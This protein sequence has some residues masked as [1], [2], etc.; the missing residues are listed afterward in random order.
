MP[1]ASDFTDFVS[2]A[3]SNDVEVLGL[4]RDRFPH[5]RF[6]LPLAGAAGVKN[7]PETALELGSRLPAHFLRLDNGRTAIPMF[8]R[9]GFCRA[10]ADR[11][12]W[13]TDGKAIKTLAV[14][15]ATALEYLQELLSDSDVERVIVNPLSAADLHLARTDIEAIAEGRHWD[16][17]WFYSKSGRLKVPVEIEGSASILSSIFRR[18]D[19]VL[20]KLTEREGNPEVIEVDVVERAPELAVGGPLGELAAEL[21]AL[22]SAERIDSIELV[23]EKSGKDVRVEATPPLGARLSR[24]IRAVAEKHWSATADDT[25][26]KLSVEGKSIVVSSS[27]STKRRSPRPRSSLTFHSSQSPF[28]PFEKTRRFRGCYKGVR[29]GGAF[30]G[31]GRRARSSQTGV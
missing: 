1:R 25:K 12:T 5:A 26:V 20:Q 29:P 16:S 23:L 9:V 21:F 6:H 11:L 4:F 8:T 3:R 18:A 24:R 10:C 2:A 17:L 19:R 30:V 28:H 14:P 7:S 22:V 15:G 31:P 13:K 27:S